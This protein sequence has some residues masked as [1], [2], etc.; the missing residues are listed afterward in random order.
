MHP[1]AFEQAA[2]AA[3]LVGLAA[4]ARSVLARAVAVDPAVVALRIDATAAGGQPG[5]L[6]EFVTED[7]R[8]V[9]GF[10]L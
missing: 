6:G 10:A 5:I 7:G 1:D 2:H 4:Y 9:G 3:E 8:A